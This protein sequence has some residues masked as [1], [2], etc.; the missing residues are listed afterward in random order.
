MSSGH[1]YAFVDGEGTPAELWKNHEDGSRT[2]DIC[3]VLSLLE[4]S[5]DH[6]TLENHGNQYQLEYN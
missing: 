1:E 3:C 4:L 6:H 5:R 2:S